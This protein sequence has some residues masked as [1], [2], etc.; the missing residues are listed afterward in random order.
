[1]RK[2]VLIFGNQKLAK[3]NMADYLDKNKDLTDLQR[4][5]FCERLADLEMYC[6]IEIFFRRDVTQEIPEGSCVAVRYYLRTP[7]VQALSEAQRQSGRV[8]YTDIAGLAFIRTLEDIDKMF[9]KIAAL[10][11]FIVVSW[12]NA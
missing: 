8:S 4:L 11:S 5:R 9:D 12:L 7:G 10:Q 3:T 1:M 6:N 2:N